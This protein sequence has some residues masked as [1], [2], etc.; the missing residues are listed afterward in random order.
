MIL[1]NDESWLFVST[2]KCATNTLYEALAH[3][4][5]RVQA[6]QM[7]AV[8]GASHP[9]PTERL[10]PRHWTVCRN[11][12]DR[13]V[14]IWASTALRDEGDKY[15]VR[16]VMEERGADWKNFAHFVEFCLLR[17]PKPRI[18]NL[19]EPQ[20]LW[21][22]TFIHDT[23]VRFE[24]LRSEVEGLV[25]PLEHFPRKNT[26][27][28]AHW[29]DYLTNDIAEMVERW[30]GEDFDRYGY[31]KWRSIPTT[32]SSNQSKTGLTGMT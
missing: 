12:Y 7:G 25:G 17:K 8:G 30:A 16:E 21:H 32:T 11:P 5:K 18:R 6:G 9:V 10:A 28:R 26:S 3:L 4:G 27:E 20:H 19:F 13:A 2:M 14:S 29:S 24:N 22:D 31:A 23:V 15:W 1:A